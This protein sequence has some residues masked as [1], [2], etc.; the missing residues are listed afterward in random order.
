MD[1]P[2]DLLQLVLGMSPSGEFERIFSEARSVPEGRLRDWFDA[3]AS[4]FG[5]R[6]AIDVVREL[7]GNAVRFDFG[8]AAA[9]LPKVDLPELVP[10]FK[11]MLTVHGKRFEERGAVLGF[12][13][14]DTWQQA[15][16][17]VSDRYEGLRFV[18]TDPGDGQDAPVCGVGHRVFDA[19]LRDAEQFEEVL[20]VVP[21]LRDAVAVFAVKDAITTGSGV[22]RRVVYGV[23]G[24]MPQFRLLADWELI[25]TLNGYLRKPQSVARVAP[26]RPS[27][28]TTTPQQHLQSARS[29]FDVELGS[30]LLPFKKPL[31]DALALLLPEA[32]PESARQLEQ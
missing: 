13:T 21:G 24:T 23:A 7:V 8:V 27:A 15:D 22:V 17:A 28:L 3:Q 18:R 29:W 12:R 30:L 25:G 14:P 1:D 32:A 26:G 9:D 10:F 5:G 11:A 19:A 20:A 16:F 4:T 6:N 2:E 31:T